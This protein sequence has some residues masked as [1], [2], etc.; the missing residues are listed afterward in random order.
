MKTTI[1]TMI[2]LFALH[3]GLLFAGGIKHYTVKPEPNKIEAVIDLDKLAPVTPA[4]AEFADGPESNARIEIKIRQLAPATPKE[5]DFEDE[6]SPEEKNKVSVAN[7]NK[8]AP[9]PPTEADFME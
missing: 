8:L 7:T 1:Y 6:L 9:A 2:F 4:F 5:A 3:T